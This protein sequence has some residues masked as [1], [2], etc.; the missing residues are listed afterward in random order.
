MYLKNIVEIKKL[1]FGYQSLLF[2]DFNLE[3]TSSFISITGS[4]GSGKS[5]LAK[6]LSG[7]LSYEGE[8][9][10]ND[11]KLDQINSKDIVLI[12]ENLENK[13]DLDTAY[14]NMKYTLKKLGYQKEEITDKITEISKNLKIE[15]ILDYSIHHLSSGE[16]QLINLACQILP[17]PKILILDNATSMLNED[18]KK[19]V[20][21]YLKKLN[22]DK[23]IIIMN[24]TSNPEETIYGTQIVLLHQGKVILNKP[25]KKALLEEKTFKS[26]NLDLPFMASLSLKLKY[27]GLVDELV[28]DMNKMVNKLWK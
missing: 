7:V 3:I 18:Q 22:H 20:F 19:N 9:K 24:F 14:D 17:E 27:Y 5:T 2:N 12:S 26:C 11:V 15:K 28:L 21:K 23:K 6:I 16:K 25:T 4:N 13:D 10:I 1:K 8:I